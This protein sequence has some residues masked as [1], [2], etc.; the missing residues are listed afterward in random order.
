MRAIVVG[1][2]GQDGYHMAELLCAKGIS[3]L[4]LTSNL[5]RAN[6]QL[7]GF[8][9]EGLI[10][11]AFDYSEVGGFSRVVELFRPDLVFNFAAKA[12]GQGMFDMPYEIS[13]LNGAFIIDIL[14]AIRTS[15]RRAV[16]TFCQASS[17]EM[18]GNV[19]EAP[20]SEIT[21][22]RPKSPYGAAKSYGHN[23][24][25]IYRVAY[26]LRCC[27]AILYNH[28]STRRTPDF[29]TMKIAHGAASIK[30]GL[31]DSL[32]VNN[33]DSSRDW[34][35][36]PEYVQGMYLMAMA[37]A[38]RDYVLSTGTLHTVRHLCEVAFSHVGL[39]YMKYTKVNPSAHRVVD[40]LNLV[41]DSSLIAREL[42]WVAR[43]TIDDIMVEMVNHQLT[44]LR[45][46]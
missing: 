1:I 10:L 20:Q 19:A 34:G 38:R 28:E 22:L 24:I 35:Y 23:M 4:G 25:G 18:F 12:T 43:R 40:S 27:S 30:L 46:L 15:E 44:R 7:L 6:R 42:G 32:L 14:E 29:V 39:D 11:Q 17:S 45:M 26:G 16:I 31:S 2:S 33:L 41:G 3:V 9:A 13:R 37:G 21:P 5:D 8:K 36:A